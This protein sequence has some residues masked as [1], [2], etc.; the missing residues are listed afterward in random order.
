MAWP[1]DFNDDNRRSLENA[2]LGTSRN[3]ADDFTEVVVH[4][5]DVVNFTCNGRSNSGDDVPH[6]TFL[7]LQQSRSGEVRY[8]ACGDRIVVRRGQGFDPMYE[9]HVSQVEKRDL[10]K[11]P[12]PNLSDHQYLQ[13]KG[14]P[15]DRHWF[16]TS[17][18]LSMLRGGILRFGV[19]PMCQFTMGKWE[20][21]WRL[22]SQNWELYSTGMNAD[23]VNTK[24]K[25][26]S[27]F[28]FFLKDMWGKGFKKDWPDRC[29]FHMVV[30]ADGITVLGGEV[31]EGEWIRHNALM[32]QVAPNGRLKITQG[33]L[34]DEKNFRQSIELGPYGD[35]FEH[36]MWG[37]G[38]TEPEYFHRVDMAGKLARSIVQMDGHFEV[39][40]SS[41]AFD[42]GEGSIKFNGKQIDIGTIENGSNITVNGSQFKGN[43]PING[44]DVP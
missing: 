20:N 4:F 37:V 41:V 28:G 10:K 14:L 11:R 31:K 24:G 32:I 19:S 43:V 5:V 12:T 3:A 9:R 21:F 23:S 40:A 27:R 2:S 34:S 29:D 22:V 7:E 18:F 39:T 6:I 44:W 13:S 42:T 25:V 33:K 35:F 26:S 8:P 16:I 36:K 15:G 17:T 30:N 38:S 1:D